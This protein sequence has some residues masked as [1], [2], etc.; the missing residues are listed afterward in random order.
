MIQLT[1]PL[2]ALLKAVRLQSVRPRDDHDIAPA[3]DLLPSRSSSP[4]ARRKHLPG[5]EYLAGQMPASLGL[6]LI[7][8]VETG[9]AGAIVQLDGPSD[10]LATPNDQFRLVNKIAP[11]Q[12]E[13]H[14][15]L[16]RQSLCQRRRSAGQSGRWTRSSRRW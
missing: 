14:A 3:R 6:D 13:L 1:D 2:D 9:D 5:N 4:D 12:M 8:D 10:G 7:L 11:M 15:R 16:D